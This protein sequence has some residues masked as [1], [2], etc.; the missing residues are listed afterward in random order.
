MN[1]IPSQTQISGHVRICIY[2]C[3]STRTRGRGSRMLA[4]AGEMWKVRVKAA[5]GNDAARPSMVVLF[6]TRFD[7]SCYTLQKEPGTP[8]RIESNMRFRPTTTQQM[9]V[10][11]R[12][13]K[14]CTLYTLVLTRQPIYIADSIPTRALFPP[15]RQ[16]EPW[17]VPDH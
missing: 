11:L 7:H 14:F 1:G 16:W 2:Y 6:F 8:P 13:L 5:K 3:P 12:P 9:L 4:T 17:L 15:P 10:I